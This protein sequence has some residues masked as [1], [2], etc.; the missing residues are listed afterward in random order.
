MTGLMGSGF[1]PSSYRSGGFQLSEFLDSSH[2]KKRIGKTLVCRAVVQAENVKPPSFQIA[3]ARRK[4][5]ERP[6]IFP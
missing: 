2:N 5:M 3:F 4:R 6:C 1:L